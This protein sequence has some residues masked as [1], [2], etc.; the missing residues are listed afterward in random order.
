MITYINL[1][2]NGH[3][4]NQLF[5]IASCIG[6]AQSKDDIPGF[7]DWVYKDYFSV[8]DKLFGHPADI[9]MGLDYLQDLRHF[10]N[11]DNLIQNYFKPSKKALSIL[12]K[13]PLLKRMCSKIGVHIR[14]GDYLSL[15]NHFP[16]PSIET[17]YKPAVKQIVSEV[18]YSD[19]YVFTNDPEW[20]RQNVPSEWIIIK[21]NEPWL[22]MF[23]L[24]TMDHIV[25]ANSTFS[26]WAA[27]LSKRKR[28]I[29]RPEKWYGPELSHVDI[30]HLF[31][32]EWRYL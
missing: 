11:V 12:N 8:P 13:I 9:D 1:G 22:D 6:I 10:E 14:R 16:I 23:L 4:G 27:Y 5:Q 25:M 31:P 26:W 21:D 17:Y 29:Y 2:K 24:N 30:S 18:G 28:I 3:L 7:P 32:T 15:P 20:C 19:I